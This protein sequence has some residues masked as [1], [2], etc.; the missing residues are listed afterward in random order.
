MIKNLKY[1]IKKNFEIFLLV[2]L[3]IITAISTSL[4]NSNKELNNKTYNNFI[5]NVYLK[6]TLTH[7]ISNLE[8]I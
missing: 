2:F 4:Y 6:K 3:I 7:I 8:Q 1:R 5:D